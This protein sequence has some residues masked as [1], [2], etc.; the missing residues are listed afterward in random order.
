MSLV[1]QLAGPVAVLAAIS[2][3]AWLGYR[4]GDDS[5]LR[6]VEQRDGR[7]TRW[8]LT[9]GDRRRPLARG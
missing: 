9:P 2:V 7:A 5:T 3:V 8:A 1:I 4:Y 6:S